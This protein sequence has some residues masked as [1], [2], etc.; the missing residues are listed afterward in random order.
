VQHAGACEEEEDP[1]SCE[2][3]CGSSAPGGCWCDELCDFFGDCCDD[4]ADACDGPTCGDEGDSCAGGGECCDGLHC[5]AGVPVP[6]GQEFCG[7]VCPISDRNKKEHFAA[8]DN[9]EIL[10]KVSALQITTWN[11]KEQDDAVRHLGPMAQ[12]F[13]AAFGLGSTDKSIFTIDADGVALASIQA[14]RAEND[15]LKE[16]L[17]QLERRLA[18]LEK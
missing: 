10:D 11:Y 4:K 12:D 6:V 17:V 3:H 2:G 15:A 7:E 16:Q 13:K 9:A 1:D 18:K 14:L 8:I 5:C